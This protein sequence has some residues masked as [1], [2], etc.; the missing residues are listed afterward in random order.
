MPREQT[1]NFDIFSAV[2][3]VVAVLPRTPTLPEPLLYMSRKLFE[4]AEE[5][6]Y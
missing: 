2:E 3:F 4:I 5:D 6:E 1:S